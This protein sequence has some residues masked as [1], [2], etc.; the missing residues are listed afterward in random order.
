VFYLD[1]LCRNVVRQW[2]I[3]Q[4]APESDFAAFQSLI[5]ICEAGGLYTMSHCTLDL[6]DGFYALQVQNKGGIFPSP[7]FC[8]GPFNETEITFL[9]GARMENKKI[10]PR[11]AAGIAAENL[12]VL[13][14]E[15]GRKRRERID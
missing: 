12:E 5:D 9:A 6:G 1:D 13:R 3:E 4:N 11:Y 15:P 8:K 7:V 14:A 10:K 2:M